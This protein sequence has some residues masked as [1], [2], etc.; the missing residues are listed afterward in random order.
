MT[1]TKPLDMQMLQIFVVTA[2]ERNMSSAAKRL[3]LT[4]SAVS[5]S[6]RQLE[7]QFGVMLFN[8]EHRPL[9]LTPAGLALR[10]RGLVLLE[11]MNRL[12]STVVDASHGIK[13]DVRV[14][15]VDSFAAT[16]GTQFI[17]ALLARSTTLSVRT[18]L[19]PFQ[20]EALIARDLDIV[21]SSDPLSD[22]DGIVRRRLLFEHFLI[23][24]PQNYPGEVRTAKDLRNL[25][26]AL[27]IVRFNRQSHVG[28]QAERFLR[29][30]DLHIPH[31]LEV[32]TADTLSAMVAGDIGWA[33]T[34]P[35]CLLQASAYAREVK[36]HFL[37]STQSGRSLYQLARKDEYGQLFDET[38]AI[39]HSIISTSMVQKLKAIHPDLPH[40][41]DIE[42]PSS[43]K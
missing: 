36:L 29:R 13:P 17:K 24:T 27:P 7:D 41:V 3:G 20:G 12:K 15:L 43:E 6:I 26:E 10:N 30:M 22:V 42:A 39:A 4:Q 40:W 14:G 16:C 21:I 23:I 33:V 11:D 25:S 37:T 38:Y 32:D 19:S 8:R 31:R 18:G 1:H 9:A 34:T 35:M 28:G 2:Q 5:Q